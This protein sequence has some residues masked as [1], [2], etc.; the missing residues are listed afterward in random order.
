MNKAIRASISIGLAITTLG[1]ITAA[2]ANAAGTSN[3]QVIYGGGEVCPSDYKFSIDKLVQAPNKGGS[4]VDN[5][6][7]DD[8]RFRANDTVTFKIKVTNTGD[9]EIS[10]LTITD[11][12]P[13]NVTLTKAPGSA[14]GRTI[15]YT[16]NNLKAK[17]S[18]EELITV[19]INN[20]T[21]DKNVI[22]LTN[23]VSAKDNNGNNASDKASFCAE[24]ETPSAK[25][26]PQVYDKTPVKKIPETGPE[27][28]PLLGLI[29]AGL[30]GL[31]M[32]RKS[33]LG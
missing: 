4:F 11:T 17:E 13:E 16:V 22:C 19:T 12:L 6:A 23:N 32:R 10:T 7:M 18:R 33:K 3:C 9:S 21:S 26:T 30:A 27:M 28:L 20:I 29:P 5:I 25:P 1:F 2:A 31:A 8:M 24:K 14:N 15:T